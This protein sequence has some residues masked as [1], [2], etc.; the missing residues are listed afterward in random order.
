[1]G[2]MDEIRKLTHPYSD[3]E[4]DY[5]DYDDEDEDGY[6]DDVP[7]AVP[8]RPAPRRSFGRSSAATSPR[9]RRMEVRAP[10]LPRYWTRMFFRSS[11]LL[12]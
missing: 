5:D 12:T 8:E 6:E 1:M 10:F 4:D 9:L 3:Q 7:A 2:L 11:T